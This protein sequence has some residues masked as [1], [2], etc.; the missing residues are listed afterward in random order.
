MWLES[1]QTWDVRSFFQAWPLH[2][3]PSLIDSSWAEK[4]IRMGSWHASLH[5][6]HPWVVGTSLPTCIFSW[7]RG[8][9]ISCTSLALYKGRC[10]RRAS[11]SGY[12]SWP[13]EMNIGSVCSLLSLYPSWD[14]FQNIREAFRSSFLGAS[15]LRDWHICNLLSIMAKN[16]MM[17]S[18]V[19]DAQRII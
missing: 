5:G 12:L 15:M 8:C 14:N 10:L 19:E 13:S 11:F 18:E 7:H 1:A 4:L 2:A 9:L 3:S 17:V 6:N 16:T